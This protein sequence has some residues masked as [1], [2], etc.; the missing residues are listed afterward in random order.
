MA[1]A[2]GIKMRALILWVGLERMPQWR[3]DCVESLTHFHP[4]L[5][6]DF[7]WIEKHMERPTDYAGYARW[8]YCKSN[9]YRLWVD[10]DIEL[11]APLPL[12]EEPF[13]AFEGGGP[14]HSILWSGNNPEY[15]D[16][17]NLFWGRIAKKVTKTVK[18][19]GLY[20]HWQTGP[21]GERVPRTNYGYKPEDFI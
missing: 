18:P 10:S 16:M 7:T 11:L 19:K 5:D 1:F 15:F 21:N 14:H 17:P 6:I 8:M 2:G 13:F 20:R 12:T 3:M 9:K 4:N